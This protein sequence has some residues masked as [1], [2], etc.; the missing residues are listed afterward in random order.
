MNSI[1]APTAHAVTSIHGSFSSSNRYTMQFFKFK[2]IQKREMR[3]LN[4]GWL[5]EVHSRLDL[6][7]VYS[8]HTMHLPFAVVDSYTIFLPFTVSLKRRHHLRGIFVKL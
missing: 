7:H 2:L 3:D 4:H 6:N 5:D 8:Y 1:M